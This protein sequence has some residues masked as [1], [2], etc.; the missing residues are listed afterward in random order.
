MNFVLIM[1][2]AMAGKLG[3]ILMNLVFLMKNKI[4]MVFDPKLKFEN[5]FSMFFGSS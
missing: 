4:V 3:F 5:S 2:A 1:V